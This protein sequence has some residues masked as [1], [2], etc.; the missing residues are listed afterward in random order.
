MKK[1][2]LATL[3]LA[4]SAVVAACGDDEGRG[5][6]TPEEDRQLDEAAKMLEDNM[7]DVSPDSLTASEAELNAIDANTSAANESPAGNGQ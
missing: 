4:A 1:T 3:I 6:I 5:G 7:I 2:K